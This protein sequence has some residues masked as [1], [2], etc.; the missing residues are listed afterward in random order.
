MDSLVG[1]VDQVIPGSPVLAIATAVILLAAGWI[2]RA[3]RSSMRRQGTR[4][5]TLERAVKSERNRR[6]QTE[7]CLREHGIRLPYWPDDPAELYAAYSGVP[8][9]HE[10]DEA[11]KTNR[12]ETQY[13]TSPGRTP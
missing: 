1:L 10:D 11:P 13:F 6:R 4:V 9:L 7:Q 2:A 8:L 3:A 5:G 12:L